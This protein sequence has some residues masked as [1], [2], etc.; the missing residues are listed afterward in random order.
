MVI[1]NSEN[2]VNI[3]H[4]IVVNDGNVKKPMQVSLENIVPTKCNP[5][6]LSGRMIDKVNRTLLLRQKLHCK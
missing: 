4:N 6:F 1:D 3:Y 2:I 5:I